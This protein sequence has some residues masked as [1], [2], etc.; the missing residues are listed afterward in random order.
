MHPEQH[1]VGQLFFVSPG[2]F[3]RHPFMHRFLDPWTLDILLSPE[4]DLLAF[5]TSWEEPRKLEAPPEPFLKIQSLEE[6]GIME[7]PIP[8]LASNLW[9]IYWAR[10]IDAETC[11]VHYHLWHFCEYSNY[12]PIPYPPI[13]PVPTECNE[14][15]NAPLGDVKLT[16]PVLRILLQ[17]IE[18]DRTSS[19]PKGSVSLP[20]LL[21]LCG[22][23]HL[24]HFFQWNEIQ[25]VMYT[26]RVTLMEDPKERITDRMCFE[27]KVRERVVE[28]P[29]LLGHSN[30]SMAQRMLNLQAWEWLEYGGWFSL[31]KRL[32]DH[33]L[34]DSCADEDESSSTEDEWTS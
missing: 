31:D 10:C 17:L 28:V 6:I 21:L 18:L 22:L 20:A 32:G 26:A 19:N 1:G 9:E 11:M 13:A 27:R 23:F 24:R 25:H 29:R 16:S 5:C 12:P 2:L 14:G 7:I 34:A 30:V 8:E 33:V 3:D 15:N 4:S